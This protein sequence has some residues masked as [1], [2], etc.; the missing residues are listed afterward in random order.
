MWDNE[1][2]D[3]IILINGLLDSANCRFTFFESRHAPFVFEQPTNPPVEATKLS[4]VST[5]SG[6]TTDWVSL[7]CLKAR[8]FHYFSSLFVLSTVHPS[9]INPTRPVHPCILSNWRIRRSGSVAANTSPATFSCIKSSSNSQQWFNRLSIGFSFVPELY[10]HE[11]LRYY[12]CCW[13]PILSLQWHQLLLLLP[14]LQLSRSFSMWKWWWNGKAVKISGKHI[15]STP[16]LT[17]RV[18]TIVSP[19]NSLSS[20]STE[21]RTQEKRR[22]VV[23][24]QN[25]KPHHVEMMGRGGSF[26]WQDK[27]STDI[28]C[29]LNG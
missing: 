29:L 14:L 24:W 12:C 21:P 26:Q 9:L 25:T 7:L 28:V 22:G 18:P 19:R 5:T 16:V 1:I 10:Q 17:Y 3:V 2:S 4:Q 27:E 20:S 15:H 11:R 23:N 8:S 6:W 13:L